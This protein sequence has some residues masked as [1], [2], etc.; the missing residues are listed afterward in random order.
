MHSGAVHSGA[1][2]RETTLKLKS[3][4]PLDFIF[5]NGATQNGEEMRNAGDNAGESQTNDNKRRVSRDRNSDG[6]SRH[7]QMTT[8][9]G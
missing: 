3:I 5:R 9:A 2:R 1:V 8:E 6:K 7:K 4:F